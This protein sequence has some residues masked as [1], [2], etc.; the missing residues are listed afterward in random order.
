MIKKKRILS[1]LMI[2]TGSVLILAGCCNEDEG[3]GEVQ[4]LTISSPGDTTGIEGVAKE[5]TIGKVTDIEGDTYKTIVIGTQTWMA[6]NL[7]TTKL[8]DGS[9]LPDV[10]DGTQWV[11]F[12]APAYCWYGNNEAE[13]KKTHGALYNWYAVGSGKLAPAGWHVPTRE[14]W[15]TLINYLG[16]E[17]KAGGRMKE[18]GLTHWNSPNAGATNASGFTALAS[19]GRYCFCSG[20]HGL[21]DKGYWW[22]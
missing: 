14:E 8:N 21:K 19:G 7:R 4:D 6:E 12:T 11:R 10:T 18:A 2:L 20:S 3:A 17:E 15:T 13:N 5:G 22:T 9:P 1:Y 16:G